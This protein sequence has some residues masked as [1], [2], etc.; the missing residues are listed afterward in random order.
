VSLNLTFTFRSEPTCRILF[1]R[2]ARSLAQIVEGTTRHSSNSQACSAPPSGLRRI[3]V[4]LRRVPLPLRPPVLA[5]TARILVEFVKRRC[6][7]SSTRRSKLVG[8]ALHIKS[9]SSVWV[10]SG[11]GAA[12]A[13]A[14]APSI[15]RLMRLA[16]SNLLPVVGKPRTRALLTSSVLVTSNLLPMVGQPRMRAL[17]TSKSAV[18][19]Q[20]QHFGRTLYCLGDARATAANVPI[21]RCAQARVNLVPLLGHGAPL[22]ASLPRTTA[23]RLRTRNCCCGGP[24]TPGRPRQ[25]SGQGRCDP[26]CAIGPLT[27][28]PAEARASCRRSCRRGWLRRHPKAVKVFRT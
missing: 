6:S 15:S 19:R 26:C 17:L 25:V 11:C 5:L 12:A 16:N 28:S 7:P 9:A 23:P 20:Q 27:S 18:Q 10:T 3:E 1:D 22:S 24:R 8:R 13:A 14:C 2:L 21:T 4:C